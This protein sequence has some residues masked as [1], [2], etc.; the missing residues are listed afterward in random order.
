M[1]GVVLPHLL[2]HLVL[3]L[4]GLPSS[5]GS[6]NVLR[7]LVLAP[8][9]TLVQKET[10]GHPESD[11]EGK[12]TKEEQHGQDQETASNHGGSP[13]EEE[14]KRQEEEDDASDNQTPKGNSA[15]NHANNGQDRCE[16]W[17]LFKVRGGL[18]I[19]NK[20]DLNAGKKQQ[21]EI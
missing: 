18:H 16:P 11:K 7:Q 13:E 19:Q 21:K 14:D 15:N 1:E 9:G 8:V 2:L 4:T 6:H 20:N 12:T 5:F 10:H 3:G 17:V